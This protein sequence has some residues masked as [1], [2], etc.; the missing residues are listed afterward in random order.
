MPRLEKVIHGLLPIVLLVATVAAVAA[1]EMAGLSPPSQLAQQ[2]LRPYWHVF[3]AY[4]IVIV[5]VMAWAGSIS[6]RL[7]QV[8]DRLGE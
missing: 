2:S 8:E 3:V 1:Q 5:L 6:K 7:A 4:T